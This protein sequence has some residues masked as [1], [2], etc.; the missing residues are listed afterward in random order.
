MGKGKIKKLEKNTDR[1]ILNKQKKQE[2]SQHLELGAPPITR[3]TKIMTKKT[4][5]AQTSSKRPSVK[6]LEKELR[7]SRDF[8][9]LERF[10]KFSEKQR[11][12]RSFI[13][14]RVWRLIVNPINLKLAYVAILKNKRSQTAG[15]DA[16]TVDDFGMKEVSALRNDL[17]SRK[18]TH[19]PRTCKKRPLRIPTF[20]DRVVQRAVANVLRAIFEPYFKHKKDDQN[21]ICQNFRFVPRVRPQEAIQSLKCTLPMYANAIE[22]DIEGAFDH[23]QHQQLLKQLR[24]K[25]QDR[26]TLALVKQMLKA[27]IMEV[28]RREDIPFQGTPQR[29]IL[30]PLLWNIAFD[31]FDD[32][33]REKLHRQI[34]RWN[35]EQDRTER[36]VRNKEYERV[37]LRVNK[38]KKSLVRTK[39]IRLDPRLREERYRETVELSRYQRTIPTRINF[40]NISR[41]RVYRFA[42]DVLILHDRPDHETTHLLQ[43]VTQFLKRMGLKVSQEKTLVKKTDK[44]NRPVKFVG[45]Q[46][47]VSTPETTRVRGNYTRTALRRRRKGV[48]VRP[49]QTRVLSKLTQMGYCTDSNSHKPKHC[50]KFLPKP[51]FDIVRHYRSLLIGMVNYFAPVVTDTTFLERIGYIVRY[52]ALF[53]LSN[54]L[55]SS[56]QKLIKK[57]RHTLTVTET[58][59]DKTSHTEIPQVKNLTNKVGRG[60]ATSLQNF[61]RDAKNSY[62][63][64]EE[65]LFD[66]FKTSIN[67]RTLAKFKTCCVCRVQGDDIVRHHVNK[68][69]NLK[70][71]GFNRIHIQLNRRVIP[72][73]DPCHQNIHMRRYDGIALK[74]LS[75]PDVA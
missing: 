72:V 23:V 73:C 39:K 58:V 28:D 64:K 19:K 29:S 17:M 13:F 26:R 42:D 30:S 25:V 74:G 75:R 71:K 66:P 60:I 40:N 8:K 34:K 2:S 22:L 36:D 7:E 20:R 1:K 51:V 4:T 45:F 16:L 14:T 18:Y 46:M 49:D 5:S 33:V 9:V 50:A 56:T 47:V 59:D 62:I 43:M 70:A 53:T 69:K 44:P 55:K 38:I 35:L 65:N 6:V 3:G 37:R 48:S 10:K 32:F 27:K 57:Y 41:I 24:K 52:S 68:L 15:V 21:G 61:W 63:R 54:K 67:T 31:D 12:N 11:I